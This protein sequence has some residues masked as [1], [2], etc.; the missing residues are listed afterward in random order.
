MTLASKQAA[1]RAKRDKARKVAAFWSS[2]APAL[3]F[4]SLGLCVYL[5]AVVFNPP[6]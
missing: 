4:L 1:R 6:F 3:V 5:A 2:S